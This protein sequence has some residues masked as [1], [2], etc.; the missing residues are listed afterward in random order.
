MSRIDSGTFK[1]L[2]DQL[3]DVLEEFKNKQL[4]PQIEKGLDASANVL[5]KNLKAE[6]PY[7]KTIP[8]FRD[9][10]YV[11]REYKSVRYVKNSK[12]VNG[13]D[14]KRNPK[15]VPLAAYLEHAVDSPYKG[16]IKRIS[17]QSKPAMIEAFKREFK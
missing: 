3:E 11:K 6:V 13:F 8:H 15:Q 12:R 7:G 17:R 9:S 2:E 5:L 1:A 10:W 16:F 4:K 14:K